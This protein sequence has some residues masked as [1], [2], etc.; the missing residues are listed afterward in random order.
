MRENHSLFD[1]PLFF[2]GRNSNLRQLCQ[3]IVYAKYSIEKI[4]L[5]SGKPVQ[6][7]YK[8]IHSLLSLVTYLDWTMIL[9]T[10]L[11]C[12]SMLFESPWPTTG[13]NLVF[14]NVYVSLNL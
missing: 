9:I 7:K 6:L 10:A 5:V 4:D 13:E 3:N 1:R 2:V 11:S 12:C 14:N 8:Q